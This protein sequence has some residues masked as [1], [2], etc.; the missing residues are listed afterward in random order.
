MRANLKHKFDLKSKTL[1]DGVFP[2]LSTSGCSLLFRLVFHLQRTDLSFIVDVPLQVGGDFSDTVISEHMAY[3]GRVIIIGNISS[4]NRTTPPEG[5]FTLT[6]PNAT[7][8]K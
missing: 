2:E 4:Y 5:S 8:L 1:L 3:N 7:F 6:K